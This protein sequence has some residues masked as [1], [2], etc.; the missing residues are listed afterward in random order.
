MSKDCGGQ[1]ISFEIDK[2]MCYNMFR[3]STASYLAGGKKK[4]VLTIE[5]KRS[6]LMNIFKIIAPYLNENNN[7]SAEFSIAILDSALSKAYSDSPD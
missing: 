1:T 4:E 6:N 3:R 5:E 7:S 2:P